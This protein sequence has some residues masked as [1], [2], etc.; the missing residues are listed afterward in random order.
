MRD[1]LPHRRSTNRFFKYISETV[2]ATAMG[3]GGRV[4]PKG[5]HR[6]QEVPGRGGVTRRRSLRVNASDRPR[7]KCPKVRLSAG[8]LAPC[9]S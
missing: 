9:T 1:C 6:A 2:G 3:L 5:T 7:P 4:G 8:P